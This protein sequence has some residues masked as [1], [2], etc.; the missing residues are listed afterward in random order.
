M[1]NDIQMVACVDNMMALVKDR[2]C[3]ENVMQKLSRE[4]EVR[5]IMMDQAMI[6]YM[7]A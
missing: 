5:E 7:I 4:A 3:L 6:K 2:I 1:Q